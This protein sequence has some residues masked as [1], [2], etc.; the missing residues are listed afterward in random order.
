MEI[1]LL[2][3]CLALLIAVGVIRHEIRSPRYAAL[4]F[5]YLESHEQEHL[6][7]AKTLLLRKSIRLHTIPVPGMEFDGLGTKP[8]R[9]AR[10]ELQ[11]TD[12]YQVAI[13]LEPVR[14]P[15]EGLD[16][17]AKILATNM[18]WEILW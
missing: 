6:T 4:L 8:I 18:G 12:I 3:V 16:D 15:I 2:V 11:A 5:L 9:I 10:S 17:Y 7:P 1:A 13:Y 14:M